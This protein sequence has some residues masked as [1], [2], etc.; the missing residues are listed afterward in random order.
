MKSFAKLSLFLVVCTVVIVGLSCNLTTPA[1]SNNGNISMQTPTATKNPTSIPIEKSPL[2]P[3]DSAKD[4]PL[5]ETVAT[6]PP[7]PTN[8]PE[9][10]T[11]VNAEPTSMPAQSCTDTDEVCIVS[12]FFLAE[13]PIGPDGRNI[14]DPSSRFGVYQAAKKDVIR[15]VYFLN[16]TGTPVRAVAD[17]TVLVAGD[18]SNASYGSYPNTYGNLVILRHQLPGLDQTVFTLYAHLSQVSVKVDENVQAGQEIGLVGSSGNIFGSTLRFEVRVGENSYQLVRNPELWL[19]PL[20]DE[21]GQLHGVLA[22]RIL[23]SSGNFVEISNIVIERLAGP[24]LAALDQFYVQTYAR[25]DLKG[26]APFEES[27]ALGDLPPGQYQVTFYLNGFYQKV[28]EIEPG[29]LTLVTFI[30]P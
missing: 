17:G 3:T 7:S 28:I 2:S 16:S 1:P 30:V 29:K 27:F 11:P 15:G 12:G 13:R 20:P 10:E 25:D 9:Q 23:D 5:P 14:L 4:T 26:L 21:N 8:A 6:T 18:D 19:P 24:G 22:G